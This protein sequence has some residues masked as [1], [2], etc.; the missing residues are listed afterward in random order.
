MSLTGRWSADE[1]ALLH[2]LPHAVQVLYLRG[3]R[4]FADEHGIVGLVR[5]VS[6]RSLV[7]TLTVPSTRGRHRAKEVAPDRNAVQRALATLEKAGL[8]RAAPDLGPFV[9]RL[10]YALQGKSAR[11]MTERMSERMSERMA[12][13]DF[14]N[15]VN[16]L[17]DM[18]ERMSERMKG[19]MIEPQQ[20][21][22]SSQVGSTSPACRSTNAHASALG[23]LCRR[24]RQ[25][26]GMAD[27]HPGR[28]ELAQAL[29][30][31]F[32]VDTLVDT[33]IHLGPR[34][35]NVGYLVAC[36][37]GR[38]ADATDRTHQHASRSGH[39]PSVCDLAEQQDV[40][41]S[42]R[43]RGANFRVIDGGVD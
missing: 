29:D 13:R 38:R 27:A 42:A 6:E 37:R 16:D 39:R 8:V 19:S 28:I 32:D 34:K 11:R 23:S 33:A 1:D 31:G 21:S 24:L 26:A 20:K 18:T 5:R 25:E 41:Q 35:R 14:P 2:E 15:S 10:P 36:V 22:K 7:E 40:E 4:R 3:L 12:E 43:E 17:P 9:F 30:E